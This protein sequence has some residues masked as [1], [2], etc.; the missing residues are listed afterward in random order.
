MDRYE[1]TYYPLGDESQTLE[2]EGTTFGYDG[3]ACSLTRKGRVKGRA[4]IPKGCVQ[5]SYRR[6]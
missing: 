2:H 4:I 3:M 1:S 6:I 5:G